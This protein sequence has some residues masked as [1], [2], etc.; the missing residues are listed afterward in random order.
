MREPRLRRRHDAALDP[1]WLADAHL[2]DKGEAP[3][4]ESPSSDRRC[5]RPADPGQVGIFALVRAPGRRR[6]MLG[7][8]ADK[9]IQA[10]GVLP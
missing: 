9:G 7:A 6:R 8:R 2:A 1:S 4:Q 10:A 5:R 3:M